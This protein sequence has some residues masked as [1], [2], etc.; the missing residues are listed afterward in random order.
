MSTS[1]S[2][3]LL[4]LDF[5][6]VLCDSCGE[7]SLSGWKATVK[8]WPEIFEGATDE[9]RDIIMEDMR[10]VRP[11]V[12]T[13]Y[14]NMLLV[15]ALFEKLHT[16]A[17]LLATWGTTHLELMQRWGL[18]RAT[19]VELFG[20][21]RDEWIKTDFDGWLAPNVFYPG[22]VD[23]TQAALASP[24]CDTYIVTTKQ[25]RFTSALMDRMA[26]GFPEERIYST[27]VSGQPKTDILKMLQGNCERGGEGVSLVFVEDKLST[28][29]K[30]LTMPELDAW[31]LYLVDWG[32]NT[33]EERAW[34]SAHPRIQLIGL[35]QFIALVPK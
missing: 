16:P 24:S 1:T 17:E 8:L 20:Q 7:S 9:Q 3:S 15:R 27:T 29:Q 30:V 18:D 11:V 21:T 31:Q 34:A 4:A 23:A 26:G 10:M 22:V 28:L 13:G 5:D 33:Q 6:G 35:Q 2:G 12:E 32:Y 25:A 19:M 14:E